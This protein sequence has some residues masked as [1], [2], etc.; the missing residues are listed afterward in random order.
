M[1]PLSDSGKGPKEKP[2]HGECITAGMYVRGRES[3]GERGRKNDGEGQACSLKTTLSREL[4]R[5]PQYLH[6]LLPKVLLQ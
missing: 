6:L 4:I 1:M 5:I 3:Y 2:L